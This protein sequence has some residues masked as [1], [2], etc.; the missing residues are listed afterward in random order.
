MLQKCT[1]GRVISH[2]QP[3]D[4]DEARRIAANIAKL[5][6]L[7][8]KLSGLAPEALVC[9]LRPAA[10]GYLSTEMTRAPSRGLNV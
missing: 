10:G 4:T 9:V 3:T 1:A 8:R 2:G 6:D 7:L 5:P